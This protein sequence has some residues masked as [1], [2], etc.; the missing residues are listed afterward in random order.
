M[1]TSV[2][3]ATGKPLHSFETLNEDQVNAKITQA[4]KAFEAWRDQPYAK[5]AVLMQQLA[6]VLELNKAKYAKSITLEMGKPF[7]QSLAEIEK[8]AWVCQ[9]Y[10]HN[11][12]QLLAKEK[13]ESDASQSYVRF[14][15]LG[16]ILAVMPWNYP[17]WQVMRFAA[18]SLMAGN[19]GLL[20]HAS[21]VPQCAVYL[22]EAFLEA[23]FNEGIFQTLLIPSK[24]VEGVINDNRVKAVTLTGSEYAGSQVAMQ[25]GK[26]IKKTVLEL[27]GSDP[28]IVLEDAP[29][30]LACEAAT[31]ARLQNAGQSCIAAKRFIVHEAVYD[32]FLEKF[33]ADFEAQILADPMDEKTTVGPLSSL[34]AL[35][36]IDQMVQESA[37]KG[38]T[39]L[40]GGKRREQPGF[41][42]EPTILTQV[43][44]GMPAY[45]QEFFGP[46]AS[47]IKVSD[48]QEAL[49]VANATEFGLSASL[50]TSDISRAEK[51][52]PYIQAGAV[53][54]N[55]MSKSDPRLPFGGVKKSGYGRELSHYGLK[56][57]VNVK[58]VWVK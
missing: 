4:Q 52:I 20:K 49:K 35:E 22:E 36:E 5:R 43:K 25:C 21:N 48:D 28:F 42:Y 39:V 14:D 44:P 51:L 34:K 45:D 1:I 6:K 33:K 37:Q 31:K 8:C 41:F 46:V 18:P 38:A 11:T 7:S 12:Q 56:E 50:W 24:K 27:G 19:V 32:S 2:N 30:N 26:L 53:F 54:V 23:G 3:P 17:F 16:I 57:F 9:Y 10:A 15:P 29:L 55:G 40:T 58:G 47:V 13:V